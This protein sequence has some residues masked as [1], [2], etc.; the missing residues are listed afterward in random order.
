MRRERRKEH[1]IIQQRIHA[2][3]L[4]RQHQQLRRAIDAPIFLDLSS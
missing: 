2:S 3:Q 4:G 1:R